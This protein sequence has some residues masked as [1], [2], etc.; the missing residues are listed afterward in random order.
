MKIFLKQLS[1]DYFIL[2]NCLVDVEM[3]V[4]HAA[5]EEEE[6]AVEENVEEEEE[7]EKQLVIPTLTFLVW[8]TFDV[9][10]LQH[11]C[12]QAMKKQKK[13]GL[14]KLSLQLNPIPI[15]MVVYH[16]LHH[17]FRPWWLRL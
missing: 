11:M 12:S 3:H 13:R 1:V 15:K 17:S 14:K 2:Y 9:L 4:L 6:E 8:K 5:L 10:S 16:F 7:E